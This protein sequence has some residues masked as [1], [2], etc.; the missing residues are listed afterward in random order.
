MKIILLA[1]LCLLTLHALEPIKIEPNFFKSDNSFEI[2]DSKVVTLEKI[3]EIDFR[4]IS[5]IAYEP[6]EDILYAIS[7]KGML[8]HLKLIVKN[9]KIIALKPLRAF[10]LKDQYGKQL[11]KPRR[12]AE[13]MS[14]IYDKDEVSILISFEREVNIIQFSKEGIYIKSLALPKELQKR[15]SFRGKNSMLES[16]SYDSKKGFITAPERSLRVSPKGMHGLYTKEGLL[17]YYPPS[18]LKMCVTEIE[19]I[20]EN[21]LL[22]LER[23]FSFFDFSF[24][25]NLKK[26]D[27]SNIENSVCKVE[28]IVH[29]D[30]QKGWNIDNFE[31]LTRYKDKLFLM[32]SDSNSMPFE[33]TILTLFRY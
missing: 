4:E 20:D 5:D 12:D 19:H 11:L 6:K 21:R 18:S 22:V 33:K 9:N 14:L 17:C 1:I 26:I 7:D 23:Y 2:L 10:F 13:G 32:I 24:E 3:G 28:D 29:M 25:I 16:L 8:Y 30:S 15:F 31:G 27:L